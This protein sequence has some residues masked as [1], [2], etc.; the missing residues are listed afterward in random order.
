M[1]CSERTNAT[2]P[3]CLKQATK[4]KSGRT[5]WILKASFCSLLQPPEILG[6]S[7]WHPVVAIGNGKYLERHRSAVP[8]YPIPP[9]S[10]DSIFMLCLS[11]PWD[12]DIQKCCNMARILPNVLRWTKLWQIFLWGTEVC[13]DILRQQCMCAAC[14]TEAGHGM[15]SSSEN[16]T[17][18]PLR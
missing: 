1:A 15:L 6:Q 13:G 9:P 10:T 3:L 17:T 4:N 16:N 2:Q 18:G 7:S 14:K 5:C 8:F 12:G 11:F